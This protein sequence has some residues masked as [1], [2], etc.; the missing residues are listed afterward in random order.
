MNTPPQIV[1]QPLR[2]AFL[3]ERVQQSAELAHAP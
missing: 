3:I 2:A 1:A